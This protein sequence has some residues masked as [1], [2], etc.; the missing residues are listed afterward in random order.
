MRRLLAIQSAVSAL[1]ASEPNRRAVCFATMLDPQAIGYALR[2][3][4][5]RGAAATKLLHA[6]LA[7]VQRCLY[8]GPLRAR[9]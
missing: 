9:R 3:N 7:F 6:G 1:L 8:G 5:T 4:D 2:L